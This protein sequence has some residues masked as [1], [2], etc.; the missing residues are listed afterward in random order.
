LIAIGTGAA[1]R[2]ARRVTRRSA[3]P[4]ASNRTPRLPLNQPAK[5]VNGRVAAEE[6]VEVEPVPAAV[7]VGELDV[8][9]EVLATAVPDEEPADA[10]ELDPE[11]ELPELEDPEE[12]EW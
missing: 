4:A 9:V 11:D 10:A 5:P 1:G 7:A 2:Y 8:V 12:L 6:L 3:S